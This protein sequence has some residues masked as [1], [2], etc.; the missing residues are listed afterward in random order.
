MRDAEGRRAREN[1]KFIRAGESDRQE[2]TTGEVGIDYL[3][4][5]LDSQTKELSFCPGQRETRLG[6]AA[7]VRRLVRGDLQPCM[8][9]GAGALGPA[10]HH[11]NP[12]LL[13]CSCLD[14]VPRPVVQV[15][16]AVSGDAQPPKTCQVL[17]SCW[18]PN[19]S[20]ITYSWR[21][22]GTT[23]F[24]IEPSSLF[25]D[26]QVL[27]VSLGPGDKSVAYSCTVSNPVSRDV[28]TVTPWE[29]CHHEA[30]LPR[31]RG[32][33]LRDCEASS[34]PLTLP[35]PCPAPGKTSY[36][37]MVLVVVPVALLLT[38]A[39]LLS[40]WHPCYS[41]RSPPDARCLWRRRTY[42]EGRQGWT[43]SILGFTWPVLLPSLTSGPDSHHIPW[44]PIRLNKAKCLLHF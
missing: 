9:P 15:F 17:L 27:K 7:R 38:L 21:R 3:L 31:A 22:E 39:G 16:I 24:G 34:P 12:C 11:C 8:D 44:S 5:G 23:D 19:I 10:Q 6:S 4:K 1:W 35:P 29:S 30:G 20:D 18:A 40:V 36:K 25:T 26:G 32:Q 33:W 2:A 13:F 28:A 43:S 42:W 14:A 41:G 37:D